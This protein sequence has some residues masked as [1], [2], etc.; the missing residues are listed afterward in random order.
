VRPYIAATVISFPPGALPPGFVDSG[1][2]S[3]VTVEV[4][5]NPNGAP[6]SNASVTLNG[7]TLPYI[8]E[9]QDYEGE[10]VVAPAGGVKLNVTVG[11]ATY[12][13]S[14]TQF[15]SYPSIASPLSGATWS[16]VDPNVIAW[17]S[18]APSASSLYIIGV[19]DTDGQVIWPAGND[20]FE[21]VSKSVTSLTVNARSLDTGSRFVTVGIATSVDI[22]SAAP[23]SNIVIGGFSYVPIIV[24]DGPAAALASIAVTPA[25]PTISVGK[26]LQLVATGTYSN[27]TTQDLT[28]QVTWRSSDTGNANVNASGLVT[29]LGYGSATI[30]ANLGAVTPG[31]AVLNIFQPNPSPPPPLSQAVAYQIDY[32]HSGFATFGSP[33]NFPSSPTWSVTLSGAASYPVIADGKVFVI[34]SNLGTGEYGTQLFAL[35]KQTGNIAWGPIAIAENSFWSG[36]AYDHGKVFVVSSNGLLRSFDAATGQAG[37]STQMPSQSA[38]SSPPTAVNGVVYLGGAGFEGTLFA[39]DES[40]GSILWT[41]SVENGDTSSPTISNDGVF[42]SYPCQ[43]YKFDPITGAALWHYAGPCEGG[44]GK[45]A[46]YANGLLYVRDANSSPAGQIFDATSGTLTGSFTSKAIPGTTGAPIPALTMQS[47]YFLNSGILQRID[48]T[49]HNVLWDFPGDGQLVSAPVV[50]DNHVIVGSANGNVFAIDASTGAQIWSGSAGAAI[51]APG[52]SGLGE[53]LTGIGAGEGY[54]IVPAGKV[55]SA[56]HLSGP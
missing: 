6:I 23:D 15:T 26:T 44:G 17:S 46:V 49:S 2:N 48:L 54:L 14:G 21:I 27:N 3:A 10:I 20:S 56:W 16:S 24:S 11:G 55:I 7:V 40:N 13:A 5:E 45:T 9:Y 35:D 4:L 22:P 33:L 52:E 12:T 43:A 53:P 25:T 32:A 47:G 29:G 34:T 36:H 31:S 39:V 18:V 38:F 28:G 51:S 37:W 19:L 30:T 8:A 50:I 1:F 42:V 41:A